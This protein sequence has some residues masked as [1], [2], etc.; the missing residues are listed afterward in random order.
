M[1]TTGKSKKK[2]FKNKV[3]DITCGV[4]SLAIPA[5]SIFLS[6]PIDYGSRFGG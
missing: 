6:F 3:A 2:L 1:E 4:R 5:L